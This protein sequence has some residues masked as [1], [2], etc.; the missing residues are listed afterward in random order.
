MVPTCQY[1]PYT[2]SSLRVESATTEVEGR[3]KGVL[4]HITG[5]EKRKGLGPIVSYIH[6]TNT[7]KEEDERREGK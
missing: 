7:R 4:P 3:E 2:C 5:D 1:N 6:H